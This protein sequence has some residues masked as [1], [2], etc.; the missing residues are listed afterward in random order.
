VVAAG[1]I[2]ALL[3]YGHLWPRFEK[4]VTYGVAALALIASIG[5]FSDRRDY[6]QLVT[7]RVREVDERSMS[8]NVYADTKADAADEAVWYYILVRQAIVGDRSISAFFGRT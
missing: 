6:L 8:T 1:L 7:N 3:A 5:Y 4:F 2:N